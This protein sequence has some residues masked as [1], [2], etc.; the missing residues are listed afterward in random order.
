MFYLTNPIWTAP[1]GQVWDEALK[2]VFVIDTSP[3]PSETGKFA[4]LIVL[5]RNL[6]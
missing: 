6:F 1:N 3:F 4:D 2:D 5:D